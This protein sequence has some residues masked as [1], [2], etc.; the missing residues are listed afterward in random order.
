MM[1]GPLLCRKVPVPGSHA[2]PWR[3]ESSFSFSGGLSGATQFGS[4]PP[5]QPSGST[6]FSLRAPI[7]PFRCYGPSG[8]TQLDGPTGGSLFGGQSGPNQFLDKGLETDG[9]M[10]HSYQSPTDKLLQLISL[11]TAYGSW[12]LTST[13]E[14]VLDRSKY[15]MEQ[16]MPVQV[17]HE[18]WTTFLALIWLHGSRLE[19]REEWQL[20][21]MK[22]VSWL[23]AQNVSNLMECIEAG[24]ALLGFKLKKD[25]PG[26]HHLCSIF[27]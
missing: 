5:L 27:W 26:L 19:A 14:D 22:A 10:A 21:A 23:R 6:L 20:L 1:Q 25:A 24:N 8:A 4:K 9:S 11:Q 16:S 2:A 13:L 3:G 7:S 12:I 15:Q 18:V 17:N